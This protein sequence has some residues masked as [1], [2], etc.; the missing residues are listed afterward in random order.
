MKLAGIIL[1]FLSAAYGFLLCRQSAVY[2]LSLLREIADDLPLLSCR[3]CVQRCSLPLILAE[4]LGHGVSGKHLWIPLAE[5]LAC[6][7]DTFCVCWARSID[8]L[9][10]MIAQRLS[11]LGKLM[12]L[13]G[14]VL[15][16]ALEEIHEELLQIVREQQTQQTVKLRLSAA[17]CFSAATIFILVFI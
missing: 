7:E 13:G 4:D 9:P 5:R 8:G 10:R 16:N 6:S 2:T 15:A 1:V 11:P 3:I 14:D 17:A 12:P